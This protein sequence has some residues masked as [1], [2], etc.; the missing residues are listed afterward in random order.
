MRSERYEERKAFFDNVFSEG[1]HRFVHPTGVEGVK[2]V[3][4]VKEQ[5]LKPYYSSPYGQRGKSPGD[6]SIFLAD[7]EETAR[8]EMFQD[9]SFSGYPPNTWMLSYKYSGNILDIGLIPDEA[10]KADFLQAS[11]EFKHEFSQDARHYLEEKGYTGTFDSLGWVSVQGQK[12]G[13]GGFVYNWISGVKPSF[14]YLEK[15]RLDKEH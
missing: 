5:D 3:E 9:Q 7:R 15:V 2:L 11:G 1:V 12:L 13:V 10:F 8:T 14:E 6:F 4:G